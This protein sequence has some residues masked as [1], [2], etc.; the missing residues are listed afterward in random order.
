MI[1]EKAIDHARHVEIQVFGDTAGNIVHLGERDCSV[2]RRNQKVIEEAPAPGMTL[3][4]RAAMGAAAVSL[5]R[6]VN[7][8]NAGTVEF[9]LDRS[10]QFYFLEMNTRIQVEHPVTEEVTGLNLVR[11]Q[12]EVAMGKPLPFEQGSVTI[13]GH[14]IEA[15]LCAEDPED[16]FKPQ[17]GTLS[18]ENF[19][20]EWPAV[21]LDMAG[22]PVVSGDYDSM[23]AKVIAKGAT[24]EEARVKLEAAL[25][26]MLPLGIRTNRRFLRGLL[27]DPVFI[28]AEME[29]GWLNRRAAEPAAADERTSRIA[30][31]LLARGAERG[32]S[33]TGVRRTPVL[34]KER[35]QTFRVDAA[36]GGDVKVVARGQDRA[37][38]ALFAVELDGG[39]TRALAKVTTSGVHVGL[40]GEDALYEDVTYAEPE[41]TGGAASGEVRSPMAGKIV[42]VKAAVGAAIAKGEIIAVLES[43]KMEHE[44]R[45]KLAG[46][47]AAVTATEGQQVA[48]NA[49]LA[50]IT[51]EG[52][53]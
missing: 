52:Q 44:I 10:G 26:D 49:L 28:A 11:L 51:P 37:G 33:S 15:R 20:G 14:A 7:Y 32:W 21:R 16:G 8:T 17:R 24:R 13:T 1:L 42:A 5:A 48:P 18:F 3:E 50:T 30:A 45:A 29:T 25:A 39:A 34:L 31:L 38:T 40:D 43:M 36:D 35:E 9:L 22:T 19:S 4:L 53:A 2:Q 27:N 47:V 41:A 12:F 6:A 46:T 23:I